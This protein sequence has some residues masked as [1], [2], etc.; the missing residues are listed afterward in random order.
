MVQARK[1]QVAR[2][3]DPIGWGSRLRSA[4][5]ISCLAPP[6]FIL[7]YL[8]Y[9]V[10]RSICIFKPFNLFIPFEPG[11]LALGVFDSFCY[12][13]FWCRFIIFKAK[14]SESFIRY[15]GFF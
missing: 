10:K 5:C 9:E 14:F 2:G 3:L 8:K 13:F 11:H 4:V 6:L 1:G 15:P 7:Q 12:Y